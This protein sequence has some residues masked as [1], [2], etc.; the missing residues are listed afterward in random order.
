MYPIHKNYDLSLKT[1]QII[2]IKKNA[3]KESLNS[4]KTCKLKGNHSLK[5]D[6]NRTFKLNH[7]R[8]DGNSD[9]ISS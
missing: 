3:T 1:Q 8:C 4:R 7:V 9:L 2:P 5:V 6:E